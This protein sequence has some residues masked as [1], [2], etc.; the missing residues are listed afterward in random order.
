MTYE[1]QYIEETYGGLVDLAEGFPTVAAAQRHADTHPPKVRGIFTQVRPALPSAG[2]ESAPAR[3]ETLEE[4][5]NR[6]APNGG[7]K[8]MMK[9]AKDKAKQAVYRATR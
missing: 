7:R 1:V 2:A 6:V 5:A 3:T 8:A 4:I 9:A